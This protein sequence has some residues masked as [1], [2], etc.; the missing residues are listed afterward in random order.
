M[1]DTGGDYRRGPHPMA[2]HI[3][4]SCILQLKRSNKAAA[5]AWRPRCR[6]CPEKRMPI[7]EFLP[8]DRENL[9][10]TNVMTTQKRQRRQGDTKQP[11]RYQPRGLKCG[12]WGA[13][14]N[15]ISSWSNFWSSDMTIVTKI[16]RI[17]AWSDLPAPFSIG[18]L[19]LGATGALKNPSG[20]FLERSIC[21]TR[22]QP[23][24]SQGVWGQSQ[25]YL[26]LALETFAEFE[27]VF[28]CLA[29]WRRILNWGASLQKR[30]PRS[31]SSNWFIFILLVFASFLF[32]CSRTDLGWS[33]KTH[34]PGC[35]S[36]GLT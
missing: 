10:S 32:S 14:T 11:I 17:G 29:G 12:V 13:K 35:F 7:W 21:H 22:I 8:R 4:K 33:A 6:P 16:P 34:P 31:K 3:S 1:V 24:V 28:F 9:E 26:D 19:P 27:I 15:L 23:E 20:F 25:N 18:G 30:F 36:R 2:Q 5:S